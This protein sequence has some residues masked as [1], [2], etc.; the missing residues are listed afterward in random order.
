MDA[1]RQEPYAR[2]LLGAAGACRDG[3]AAAS[4]NLAA[5]RRATALEVYGRAA[6]GRAHSDTYRLGSRPDA[7]SPTA[8]APRATV[9]A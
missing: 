4:A 5:K 7:V 8:A 6:A 1:Y 3:S 9:R 2:A